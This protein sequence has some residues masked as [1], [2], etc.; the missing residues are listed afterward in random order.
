MP[1]LAPLVPAAA[2]A[3]GTIGT[4]GLG[5]S[6]AGAAATATTAATAA[7]GVAGTAFTAANIVAGVGTVAS[8]AGTGMSMYGQAQAAKSQQALLDY[9]AD[10]ADMNAK[11][12]E[13][14]YTERVKRTRARNKAFLEKQR[15]AYTAAGIASDTGTALSVMSNSAVTLEL[16]ALNQA[17]AGQTKVNAYKQQGQQ[18]TFESNSI[19]SATPL[20]LGATALGGLTKTAGLILS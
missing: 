11:A 6:A 15:G 14:S 4:L 12:E 9:N 13:Q 10:V 7:T 20:A 3:F 19:A 18:A 8:I 2:S 17:Y 1:F 16:E 5:G